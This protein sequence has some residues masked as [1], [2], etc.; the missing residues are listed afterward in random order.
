MTYV[1]VI[2]FALMFCAM[3]LLDCK[4]RYWMLRSWSFQR[5]Y[6]VAAEYA[7]EGAI[8]SPA[9]ATVEIGTAKG[10]AVYENKDGAWHCV[11]STEADFDKVYAIFEKGL[12]VPAHLKL[13]GGYELKANYLIVAVDYNGFTFNLVSDGKVERVN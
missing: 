7:E 12:S 9:Q 10:T 2:S 8:L 5:A 11:A 3:Y 13:P 4:R 1:V 6:E